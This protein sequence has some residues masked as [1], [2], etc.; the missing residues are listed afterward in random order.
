MGKPIGKKKPETPKQG[1]SAA[2]PS[3]G[4][5]RSSKAFDEDTAIFINM[6]QE[7]KEEGNKLY[8][9]HDYEGAMLKFEKALKLLPSNYIDV[10]N[11]RTN[12]AG[13]YMQM[14]LGEY[15]RAINECNLALEVAP[16]Y[17]KAF[18]RRAKC[19]EGFNRLDLAW[20]D[21]CIVLSMEPNNQTALEL[22]DSLKKTMEE[23]GIKLDDKEIAIAIEH[24]LSPS[25]TPSRKIAKEK[26]LT[27][28][29]SSKKKRRSM[30]GE[31]AKDEHVEVKKAE[32]EPKPEQVVEKK[33]RHKSIGKQFKEKK[34]HARSKREQVEEDVPKSEDKEVVQE[35]VMVKEAKVISRSVKL[36]YGDD[37]R[38]AQLPIN[39]NVFL[40]RDVV[41]DRFP[42]LEGSL[43]KYRDSEGDLVTITTTEELRKAEG[44][45]DSQ[46]SLRL[47]IS[48]VSPDQE[49]TYDG[50]EVSKVKG[51]VV[52][53]EQ[54][55]ICDSE[56]ETTSIDSW[57]IQFAQLF[58]NHAGFDSDP[59]LDQHE[60][61]MKIYSEAIEDTI[62][63]EDAQELFD[64]ASDKFQEMAALALF[65]MGNVHMSKAR[66]QV[67][68]SED[69]LGES[70]LLQ[71]KSAFEW[72]KKEYTKACSKYEEALKIKPDFY[73]GHLALGQ[74]QFELAKLCWHYA[75]RDL[76]DL[77]SGATQEI[78]LLYNKAE[79][80]MEAGMQIWEEMEERRL[81][82]LSK[83]EKYKA[84]LQKL[85]LDGL[86]RD[87]SA[88][89]AKEQASILRS[90][91]YILWGTLLY[92]RSIVEF[93]LG[94][95][96]WEEC[97]EVAVE[98]FELA[99]ASHTD[100]TVMIKNHCSNQAA[101]AGLEFKIDE[102]VQAWNEMYD[103]KRW[104]LGVP[105]NRLEPLFR[106]RVPKIH[107]ILEHL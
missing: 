32:D 7:F 74:Q 29:K 24:T 70:M 92:E 14:G 101:P 23:R 91:I 33:V 99:G 3:K 47:Y 98:K 43:V 4:S 26:K 65:N 93:K 89:E 97:L 50:E 6:S 10:A 13:C 64:I 37:I 39:C 59:Y 38:Y 40:M 18:L 80:S 35:K 71:I 5:D 56:K 63:S 68:F 15:P 54:S 11:L 60:I 85:G 78:L 2:K 49:P 105:S 107:H 72:A 16:K 57:I 48:E 69:P 86:L 81:N 28:E 104:Q 82:G 20:R 88:D 103:A 102:I 58:K 96:S 12:M 67:S 83:E 45:G 76:V 66:K 9:K 8:Q 30:R 22:S 17:T 31:D 27:K 62:S 106:R 73:E 19:F 53:S 41:R 90:Q 42:N 46:G 21:V 79:D 77:E 95:P 25:S 1:G 34:V 55:E 84:K 61:G 94:L 100:I 51:N 36:V 52:K 87:L 75:Q 44:S